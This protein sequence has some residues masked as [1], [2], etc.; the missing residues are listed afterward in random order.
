MMLTRVKR[1]LKAIDQRGSISLENIGFA[2]TA[3]TLVGAVVVVT[4]NTIVLD[5]EQKTHVLNARAMVSAVEFSINEFNNGPSLNSNATYTLKDLYGADRLSPSVDPSSDSGDLYEAEES[6]ILV[7]NV[8]DEDAPSAD[9][10]INKFFVRLVRG[11]GAYV[12]LDETDSTEDIE[13]RIEISDLS[14][15]DILIPR[16]NEDGVD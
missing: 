9:R 11:D 7:Q 12:Y 1:W 10:S 8:I 5:T 3:S 2:I 14:R 4:G 6:K 16:R 13:D 15:E